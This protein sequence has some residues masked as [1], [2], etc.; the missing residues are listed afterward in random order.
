MTQN[1]VVVYLAPGLELSLPFDSE[2]ETFWATESQISE[3]FEIDRSGVNRHLRNILRSGE[4]EEE[5][6]VQKMHIAGSDRPTSL[7]S[8]DL[9]LAVGYRTNSARAIDFRR[10]ASARLRDYLVKGAAVNEQRLEQIGSIVTILSRSV[11][12]VV[13]GVADVVA[14]YLPGLRLLR[15]Y[16]EGEFP[17]VDGNAPG[18]QLTVEEARA[19]IAQVRAEFPDDTLFGRERGD[20]LASVVAAIYQGFGG[21]DLYSTAEEKAANLLYFVVKDHPLSDG[22]KRTAAALF[23]TFLSR[24]G[25]LHGDGREPK[26]SNNTLAALTLLVAM[27]EP[28]EKELMVSLIVRMLTDRAECGV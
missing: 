28:R 5:S 1:E 27:S 2:Q 21:A 12:P 26:I 13:A 22:N 15:D 11:D 23:V 6:N 9:I 17:E 20:A 4:V 19:V 24:N 7:Y 18:W 14:D 25:I 8:L 16:D 10:W 3:L